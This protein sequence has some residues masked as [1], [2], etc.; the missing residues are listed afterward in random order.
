M[1]EIQCDA[2]RVKASLSQ[3]ESPSDELQTSATSA[4]PS[5]AMASNQLEQLE[6][7]LKRYVDKQ[8]QQFSKQKRP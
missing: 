1:M 4:A 2:I 3:D 5:I 6:L 8:I 7:S